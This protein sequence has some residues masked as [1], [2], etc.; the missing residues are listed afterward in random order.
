MEN[1][2][3]M[4]PTE[5]GECMCVI[6]CVFSMFFA[7]VT[8]SWALRSMEA[9]RPSLKTNMPLSTHLGINVVFMSSARS[10]ASKGSV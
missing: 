10:N 9:R 3:D 5:T 6:L 1:R 4:P 7:D 2:T 8:K